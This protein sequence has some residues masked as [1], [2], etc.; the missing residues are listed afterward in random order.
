MRQTTNVT[1]ME[2]IPGDPG[3]GGKILLKLTVMIRVEEGSVD[4]LVED[5]YQSR[6][7]LVTIMKI[8]VS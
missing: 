1:C 5:R 6:V 3:V 2:K 4:N 7:R 8:R